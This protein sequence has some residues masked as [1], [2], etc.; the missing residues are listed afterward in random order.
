[1]KRLFSKKRQ[2]FRAAAV[3]LFF[4]LYGNTQ[5]FANDYYTEGETLFRSNNPAEAIPLL[6]DAALQPDANPNV[7]VYLGLC[8][9]QLGR[10]DEAISAFMRGTLA[11]GADT[12]ALFFNAGNVYFDQEL[13]VQAEGMYTR[14]IQ[15]NGSYAPAYLNRA[16]TRMKMQLYAEAVQDYSTYLTL[17]PAST[18]KDA[19]SSLI[20]LLQ[21]S[22]V[23]V[24]ASGG[25][26]AGYGGAAG[27][28]GAGGY[29]AGPAGVA[30]AAGAG[31][32]GADAAGVAGAGVAGAAGAGGYGADAAGVAG[33]GG[34]GAADAAGGY[35]DGPAGTGGAAGAGGYGAGPAGVAG[36]AGAGGY[37]ADAAGVAGAGGYG[38]GP[39]GVA[40]AAGAGGY[41]ADAAG[42]AGAG[43]YGA[44]AAGAAGAGGYGAD[45]AGVAGAGGAAGMGGYGATRG[46][47]PE[48]VARYGDGSADI[49]GAGAGG[50]G[51]VGVA[52][53]VAATGASGAG[54]VGSYSPINIDAARADADEKF[55]RLMEEITASL[56]AVEGASIF[57]AGSENVM[58]YDEEGE[59]E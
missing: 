13:F 52:G 15:A 16:N 3:L 7:F 31:G 33:A 30:G 40:G 56:Q 10:Y 45:A 37:G 51:T 38:A 43:G 5:L 57:S 26:G 41:G 54:Y 9:H 36:A 39:A 35:G 53:T 19:I 44:D 46:Y 59:I 23:I 50:T 20:A 28:A 12:K 17:D 11:R 48:G 47:G 42:V 32:Y 58:G 8:Y 24:A 49:E 14:A 25:D 2:G 6:Q 1:M 34:Y 21:Q 27:V 22:G 29:G 18:Q 4:L 55:R